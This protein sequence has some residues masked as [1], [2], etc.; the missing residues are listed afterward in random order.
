[1]RIENAWVANSEDEDDEFETEKERERNGVFGAEIFGGL[2]LAYRRSLKGTLP[3]WV[4]EIVGACGESEL[5]GG[6]DFKYGAVDVGGFF[7]GWRD[8]R[9][10]LGGGDGV[11]CWSS[12][13]W[14]ALLRMRGLREFW[15][16]NCGRITGCNW[17]ELLAETWVVDPTPVPPHGVI[18]GLE[19]QDWEDAP[20]ELEDGRGLAIFL[21]V[22]WQASGRLFGGRMR[23]RTNG[24]SAL[25]R[26]GEGFAKGKV[27]VV[28]ALPDRPEKAGADFDRMTKKRAAGGFVG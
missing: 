15:T 1:M 23:R 22:R 5:G 19:I 7:D 11:R 9:F 18:P 8:G 2:R 6:M 20:R 25:A 14:S 10:E 26:A 4:A 17:R 13:G 27:A 12:R 21:Q 3:R 28:Q 24:R 16:W